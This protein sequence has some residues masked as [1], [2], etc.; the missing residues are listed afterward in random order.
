MVGRRWPKEIGSEDVEKSGV[1][2]EGE[3]KEGRMTWKR[4]R[5]GKV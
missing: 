5:N 1:K 3:R 4:R 2:V